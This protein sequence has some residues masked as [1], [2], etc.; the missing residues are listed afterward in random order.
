MG[1]S[2]KSHGC[3]IKVSRMIE[4]YFEGVLG[5]FK[6]ISWGFKEVQ[7]CFKKVSRCFMPGRRK[8]QE[9]F[10]I[11]KGVPRVFQRYFKE[12]LGK[13][14]RCFKKVTCCMTLIAASRGEGG[15]VLMTPCKC[16]FEQSFYGVAIKSEIM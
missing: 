7:G 6:E 1:V 12:A 14:S 2:G 8:F 9:C 13:L 15:L 4:W 11:F 16:V 3:Y 5:C 10:M